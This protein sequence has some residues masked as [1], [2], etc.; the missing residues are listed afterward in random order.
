MLGVVAGPDPANG[1]ALATLL[2]APV[3]LPTGTEAV[4][5]SELRAWVP[6]ALPGS[7]PEQECRCDWL[8]LGMTPALNDVHLTHRA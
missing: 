7:C 8:F 4:R 1:R 3:T 6:T 2:A 5:R